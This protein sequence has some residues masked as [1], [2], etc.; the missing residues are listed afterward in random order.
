M[1]LNPNASYPT[2]TTTPDANY[3]YGGAQNVTTPGDNTGTPWNANIVND[4]FGFQQALLQSANIT[5]TNT[6]D[7]AQSSQYLEALTKYIGRA[8]F[9]SRTITVPAGATFSD[10][11]TLWDDRGTHIPRG[12]IL[13]YDYEADTYVGAAN[14]ILTWKGYA[15]GGLVIHKGPAQPAPKAVK[16]TGPGAKPYEEFPPYS[17]ADAERYLVQVTDSQFVLFGDI[18]FEMTVSGATNKSAAVLV[19]ESTVSFNDCVVSNATTTGTQ[20]Y[21]VQSQNRGNM[22]LSDVDITCPTGLAA[23]VSVCVGATLKGTY[24]AINTSGTADYGY[25]VVD[26]VAS[27]TGN[28]ISA[29]TSLTTVDRGQIY[30]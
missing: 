15:G 20:V 2:Q 8:E 22:V 23:D 17:N 24:T 1:A 16:F 25:R 3:P 14:E 11:Q 28:T 7:T 4:I 30:T 27:Y 29:N 9:E 21:G 19:T 26:S 6:P 13:T 10:I 12:V 5:P 18:E